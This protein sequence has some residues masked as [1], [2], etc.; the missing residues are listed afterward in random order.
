[1]LLIY[2]KYK[3]LNRLEKLCVKIFLAAEQVVIRSFPISSLFKTKTFN[4]GDVYA[5][6]QLDSNL[7]VSCLI[8]RVCCVCKYNHLFE[9]YFL[10]F[11][12]RQEN[13]YCV[14]VRSCIH[15][16][17]RSFDIG[18]LFQTKYLSLD[19]NYAHARFNWW[20]S[21]WI[22]TSLARKCNASKESCT[23]VVTHWR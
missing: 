4:A 9:I 13:I 16:P 7:Q 3:Y 21:P 1:M 6:Q 11:S 20:C 15:L 10:Y 5:V 22:V 19:F 17:Q 14:C 8:L 12:Y 23:N 2:L 18:M